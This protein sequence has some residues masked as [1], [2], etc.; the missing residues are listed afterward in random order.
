M[1]P[2]LLFFFFLSAM[3]FIALKPHGGDKNSGQAPLGR[4]GA[5]GESTCGSCH[6]GGSYTGSMIFELGAENVSEYVPGET[7][8]ITFSG[9]YG[10]PR[11]G[12]SIT[13]LDASEN[14]AGDFALINEENTSFGTLGNGRQYVGQKAADATNEWVFEWTAPAQDAGAVTFY[15]VIN[16]TNGNNATSGDFVETGSTSVQPAEVSETFSLTLVA[17][18]ATGGTLDG[19][20]EYAEGET[21]TVS[22]NPNEGYEFLY[23]KDENGNE[24]SNLESFEFVMPAEDVTLFATFSFNTYTITFIIEDEAGEPIPDAVITFD[25]DEYDA[26]FY[27][28]EDLPPASYEYTVSRD[29]YFENSGTV[30]VTDEDVSITVV[31]ESDETPITQLDDTSQVSIFPNPAATHI[32]IRTNHSAMEEIMVF[33][34]QG[35]LVYHDFV[36]TNEHTVDISALDGAIYLLQIRTADRVSTHRVLVQP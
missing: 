18:P 25:G 27:V 1:K 13:A 14:P 7:Y 36:E 4:T 16:A 11:Y 30:A 21:I 34:L 6:S 31:L 22:A 26:G 8:I 35:K 17:E 32:N 20:G 29:G 24:L 9:E 19:E 5:P 2:K 3:L 23:W 15:Y 33:D 28:F 10:A 12:F